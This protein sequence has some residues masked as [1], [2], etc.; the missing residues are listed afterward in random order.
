M[1]FLEEN[2]DRIDIG[3]GTPL[4]EVM[5]AEGWHSF[6]EYCSSMKETDVSEETW[7]GAVQLAAAAEK[8]QI[9]ILLHQQLD[10]MPVTTYFNPKARQLTRTLHLLYDGWH[11]D[12]VAGS[13]MLRERAS[14]ERVLRWHYAAVAGS[15]MLRER[16]SERVLPQ[17]QQPQ[18]QPQQSA[19]VLSL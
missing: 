11:Y 3:S 15:S 10:A 19:T 13:S 6:S 2:H 5:R 9:R 8:F 12:A 1:A 16:A 14:E 4:S 18:P 7:G 17:P